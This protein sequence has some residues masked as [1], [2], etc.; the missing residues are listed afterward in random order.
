[1]LSKVRYE[2]FLVLTKTETFEGKVVVEFFLGD[3]NIDDLFL[4][5]QGVGVTD[6]I[7]NDDKIL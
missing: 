1:M 4:D 2:L 5:F 7:V 3:K 6:L